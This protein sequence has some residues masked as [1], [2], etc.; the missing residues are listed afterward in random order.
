M[1]FKNFDLAPAFDPKNSSDLCVRMTGYRE[2]QLEA[3]FALVRPVGHWKDTIAAEVRDVPTRLVP[4]LKALI[5]EAVAHYT[6]SVPTID[7]M[8]GS[9]VGL[10]HLWVRAAGYYAAVGA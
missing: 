9:E 2:E 10:D 5:R 3:A 6:G 8:T 1:N 4:S 7:T